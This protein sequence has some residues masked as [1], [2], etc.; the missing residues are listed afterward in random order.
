MI[1]EQKYDFRYEKAIFQTLTYLFQV[2][3]LYVVIFHM[4]MCF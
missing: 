2:Y 4:N 3:I 1:L